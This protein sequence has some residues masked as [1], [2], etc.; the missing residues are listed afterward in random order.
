MAKNVSNLGTS[1]AKFSN[2]I[3]TA[4]ETSS[5]DMFTVLGMP[6]DVAEIV[7][8]AFITEPDSAILW[9]NLSAVKFGLV[10]LSDLDAD[11]SRAPSRASPSVKHMYTYSRSG[12]NN[13]CLL[14]QVS[15]RRH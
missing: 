14:H 5:I 4:F 2:I 1:G 9:V 12:R 11:D 15:Q 3:D 6:P 8:Q 7:H 10:D 13:S